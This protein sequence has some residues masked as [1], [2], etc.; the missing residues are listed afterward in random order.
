MMSDGFN[1]V[2]MIM[3]I[4]FMADVVV[5]DITSLKIFI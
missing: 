5:A 2:K 1:R 3:L 4:E